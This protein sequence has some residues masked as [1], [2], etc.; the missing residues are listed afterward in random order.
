MKRLLAIAAALALLG[1]GC[2]QKPGAP[3]TPPAEEQAAP[4]SDGASVEMEAEAEENL[5]DDRLD[6]ALKDLDAVE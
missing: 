1:A 2:P 4:T 3:A 5:D 6:E